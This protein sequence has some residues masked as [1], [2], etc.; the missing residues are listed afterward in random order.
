MAIH[1][2]AAVSHGNQWLL[3]Y[4]QPLP[5]IWEGVVALEGVT[6]LSAPEKTGKTS[7]QAGKK[8]FANSSSRRLARHDRRLDG[9]YD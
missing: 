4:S 6:L 1:K 9:S 8:G 3:T 2:R 7:M 5:W